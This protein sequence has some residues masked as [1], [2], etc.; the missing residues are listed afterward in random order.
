[1]LGIRCQRNAGA[2]DFAEWFGLSDPTRQG[3]STALKLTRGA[4]TGA[5]SFSSGAYWPADGLKGG[6]TNVQ[7]HS[8]YFTTALSVWS[9][10]APPSRAYAVAS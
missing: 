6:V 1:M 7:G 3:V 8:T 2:A 9:C 10:P 4:A 5:Y